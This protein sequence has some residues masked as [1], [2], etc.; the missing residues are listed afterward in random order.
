MDFETGRGRLTFILRIYHR[1]RRPQDLHGQSNTCS[2]AGE[3]ERE[4]ERRGGEHAERGLSERRVSTHWRWRRV[5]SPPLPLPAQTTAPSKPSSPP[6]YNYTFPHVW[7]QAAKKKVICL[8]A[9]IYNC[10]LGFLNPYRRHSNFVF[11]R[12]QLTE[13]SPCL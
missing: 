11:A 3:R 7:T 2:G 10:A 6:L 12:R 5:R 9:K 8:N 1:G 4:G 13:S